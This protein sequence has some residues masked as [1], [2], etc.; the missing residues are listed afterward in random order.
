MSIESKIEV[1]KAEKESAIQALTLYLDS[2]Y[3]MTDKFFDIRVKEDGKGIERVLKEGLEP[4]A[5]VEGFI[6]ELNSD[7]TEYESIRGKLQSDDFNL[8]LTEIA[9]IGLAFTYSGI[10]IQKQIETSQKAL[11]SIKKIIDSLMDGETQKVDFSQ[12]D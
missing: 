6:K 1:I 7:A 12:K 8:S 11:G 4:D 5:K 10:V 2:I 9:R 3:N